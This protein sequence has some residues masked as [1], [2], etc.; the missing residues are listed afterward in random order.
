MADF[1]YV[2]PEYQDYLASRG[3]LNLQTLLDWSEGECVGEHGPR[4]IRRIALPGCDKGKT[5]YLRKDSK[6]P[7]AEILWDLGRLTRP[8]S[9]CFKVMRG[10]FWLAEAGINTLSLVCLIERRLLDVPTKAAAV[11]TGVTGKDLY[12]QLLAFGR[13]LAR[14]TNPPHRRDLLYELGAFIAQFH[15]GKLS[16]PDFV[17]K[18]VYVEYVGRQSPDRTRWRFA[19]IDVENLARKFSWAERIRQLDQLLFSLRGL[20]TA[21]DVLRIMIGYVGL[22]RVKSRCLRRR[23]LERFFPDGFKWIARAREECKLLRHYPTDQ[24]LPEE[25]LYERINGMTVH[26]GLRELLENLELTDPERLFQFSEGS[27]LHKPRLA[28]RFRYRFEAKDKDNRSVWLYI[29]R[30]RHPSL[31]GQLGRI[32]SGTIRHSSCWHE[33]KIIKQLGALRIPAP[34]VVAYGEKMFLGY[35]RASFLITLGIVGQSLERYVPK[36]L[37]RSA[38]PQELR[39]RR[40][41][42]ARLAELIS[43]FHNA[44]YCHRDLYLSHVFIS[45]KSDGEPIFYLIDLARCFRMYLRKTRWIVKDL[46][47]LDY[48]AGT[49]VTRTDRLRFLLSYLAKEKLDA[50]SKGLIRKIAAKS[51][52]IAAHDRRHPRVTVERP[53]ENSSGN[54]TT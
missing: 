27:A 49:F 40:A 41:W 10:A 22:P 23:M 1:I 29:K 13:P 2:N 33:R 12:N 50:A 25:R 15:Q 20:L 8:A 30:T 53:Y 48:S 51:A 11:V 39:K 14:A 26:M 38:G 35:E 28:G 9:R 46:A 36:H 21:T 4:E 45:F 42:I 3:M 31:I 16:W 18:H 6:V 5:F 54:R 43:R 24:L 44:G 7:L 17:A 32:L 34:M 47:G 19:L 52:K 37:S